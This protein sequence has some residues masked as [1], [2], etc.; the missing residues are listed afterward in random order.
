MFD[1]DSNVKPG[2]DIL[3][4][5]YLKLTVM[6]GFEHTVSILFNDASKIPNV[7]QIILAQK[8]IY[9]IFGSRK[10]HQIHSIFK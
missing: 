6:H 1:R 8:K 10:Y 2:R 9:N 7:N 5:H 4:T 3:K